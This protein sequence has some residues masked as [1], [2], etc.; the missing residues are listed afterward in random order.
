MILVISSSFDKT[1][2]YISQKHGPDEFY[3]FNIDHLSDYEISYGKNGFSLKNNEGLTL[4][5]ENCSSIYYRKPTPET[6]PD[7]IKKIYHPHIYRE[8][9]AFTDGITEAFSGTCLTKPSILRKADNKIFQ[10][11]TALSLGFK[12]PTPLITNCID[13][14]INEL[15]TPILKPLSSGIIEHEN[16][17][18]FVQTNFVDFSKS[19][20]TLKYS[21]CYF[22]NF[23]DKDYEV[24]ITIIDEHFYPVKIASRNK[25]D[26]RKNNNHI[27]YDII[28][29]PTHIKE[30]SLLLMKKLDL[31]FGCFDF[32]VSEGEWYYLEVNAN[33]QWV[34]LEIELG[35]DI[36][37]KIMDYLL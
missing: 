24:R 25:L 2:D 33:G 28:D 30:K 5:E 3:R 35:L 34:W 29:I 1:I 6:L 20:K 8:V 12:I 7:F 11:R 27:D 10:L 9:F 23:Q 15:T 19:T 4:S 21:P 36:S 13:S 37:K 31:K 17:K 16:K 26:W 22:Q 14:V 32:I 18:E